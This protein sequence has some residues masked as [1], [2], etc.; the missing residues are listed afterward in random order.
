VTSGTGRVVVVG[1]GVLGTMHALVAH[2]LGY[3]VVHLE[4]DAGPR[5]ASV[6]NFGLVWISG[7]A[8]GPELQAAQRARDLW[9]QL[10]GDI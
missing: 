3:E 1:A 5:R 7:R 4:R 9:E 8:A 10:A 6:R 2:R